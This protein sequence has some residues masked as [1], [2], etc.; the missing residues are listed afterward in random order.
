MEFS[1]M[2]QKRKFELINYIALLKGGCWNEIIQADDK[3]CKTLTELTDLKSKDKS[4]LASMSGGG[5]GMFRVR[6]ALFR[7]SVRSAVICD[8]LDF[9][10]LFL[11]PLRATISSTQRNPEKM[12]VV[13]PV[14]VN[15]NFKRHETC[16]YLLKVTKR[17]FSDVNRSITGLSIILM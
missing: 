11:L 4:L 12:K 8:F 16:I 7:W 15:T 14:L 6:Q 1:N 2:K 3:G 9:C 17:S 13:T 10:L 5:L